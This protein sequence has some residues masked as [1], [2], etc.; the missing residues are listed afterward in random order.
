[1][2]QVPCDNV[3]SYG[4]VRADAADLANTQRVR[5]LVEKPR[6]EE[7]PS[8][9]AVV[10]RYVLPT[11]VFDHLRNA[12]P[13]AG[14]EIQLTDAIAALLD[15]HEIYACE[16]TGERHDVGNKLGLAKAWMRFATDDSEIGAGFREYAASLLVG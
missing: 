14:G 13:G 10:V 1:M 3:S 5:G 11:A 16:L 12:N 2:I 4:V 6:Q 15:S 8:N 9:V 7:A